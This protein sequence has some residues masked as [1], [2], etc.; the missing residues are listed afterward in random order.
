MV[1]VCVAD[2]HRGGAVG[3]GRCRTVCR[4]G[5][6]ER[7]LWIQMAGQIGGTHAHRMRP[8]PKQGVDRMQQGGRG[9]V[10]EGGPC[11]KWGKGA[12]CV[13]TGRQPHAFAQ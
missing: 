5:T 7:G 13:H 2:E 12:E 10:A 4:P 1:L 3:R 9:C 8:T 6:G 11:V